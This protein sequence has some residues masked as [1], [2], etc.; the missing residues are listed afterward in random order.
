MLFV[1]SKDKIISYIVA[2]STVVIL[3]GI[4]MFNITGEKALQTSTNEADSNV[5]NGTCQC[6]INNT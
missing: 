6:Y 5:V 1:L 2:F 4:A 3:I